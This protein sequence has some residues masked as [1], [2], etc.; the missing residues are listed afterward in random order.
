M[1][2]ANDEDS[3]VSA[4]FEGFRKTETEDGGLDLVEN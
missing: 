1:G 2:L 3:H 4:K